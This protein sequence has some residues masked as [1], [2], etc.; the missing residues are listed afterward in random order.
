[1]DGPRRSPDEVDPAVRNKARQMYKETYEDWRPGSSEQ[2]SDPPAIG[3][4]SEIH[5]PTL[6]IVGDLDMPGILEIA[7]MIEKNIPGSKKVVI[8]G[9]AHLVNMEKP[10]E[11]NAAVFDFLSKIAVP[12]AL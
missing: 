6:V 9:G 10:R 8:K 2:R 7:D 4:L 3:R 1:M 5:A 12:P 11:F